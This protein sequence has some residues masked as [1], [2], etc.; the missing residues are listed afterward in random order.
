M[1]FKINVNTKSTIPAE[2]IVLNSSDPCGTSPIETWTMYVV[3]VAIGTVGSRV[4]LG[5]SPAATATIIVSPN[6]REIAR[7]TDTVIPEN[8]AGTNTLNDVWNLDAPNP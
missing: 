6:A 2:K 1:V 3:M 5:S 7:I 4:N 8:A